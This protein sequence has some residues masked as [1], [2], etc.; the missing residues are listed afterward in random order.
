MK[1]PPVVEFLFDFRGHQFPN[2]RTVAKTDPILPTKNQKNAMD[3]IFRCAVF[4]LESLLALI[5]LTVI[6]DNIYKRE[7]APFGAVFIHC[8]LDGGSAI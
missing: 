6:I 7:A 4:L 5:S 1:V 2:G 3:K 8:C